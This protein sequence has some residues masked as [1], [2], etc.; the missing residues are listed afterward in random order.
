MSMIAK[1]DR[2]DIDRL[3]TARNNIFAVYGYYYSAPG[4]RAFCNRLD[5]ILNKMDEV[6][7]IA[8]RSRE[9]EHTD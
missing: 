5:T 8:E 9:N 2:F 6:I 4:Y 1:V 3:E 7:A